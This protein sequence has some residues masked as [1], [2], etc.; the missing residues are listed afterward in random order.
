MSFKKKVFQ[1]LAAAPGIGIGYVHLLNRGRLITPKRRVNIKEVEFEVTRFNSALEAARKQLQLIKKKVSDEQGDEHVYLIEAQLLMLEDKSLTDDTRDLIREEQ[2]N[3]EWAVQKSLERF[4]KLFDQIDDEYF[5]DRRSDIEYVEERLLRILTEAKEQGYVSIHRKT[6]LVAH[7]LSPADIVKI[8]RESLA[9]IVTDIGGRTSHVS[10]MARSLGVPFVVGSENISLEVQNGERIIVDGSQG[11]V[12][13]HPDKNEQSEYEKQQEKYLAAK[14]ELLKNRYHKAETRDH[15]QVHLLANIDFAEEV[16]SVMENGAEGIGMLRTENLFL[17]SSMPVSEEKQFEI[18]KRIVEKMKP[19]ETVIRLF[20]LAGD[21]LFDPSLKKMHVD[22]N[23]ALGL[24]GIRLLLREPDLLRPQLRAILRASAFG[25]V[26]ILYPMVCGVMEVRKA[27]EILQSVMK[28][29]KNDRLK[30]D[31]D[32]R[33]GTMVEIPSAA[34]TANRI[35]Q[36]VDFL[37]IG[38]NDL[39]QYTL[40]VDRSNDLVAGLYDPLHGAVIQLLKQIV[41]FGHKAAI[42]VGVCGEV[43]SEP[44]FIPLLIG[45]EFNFLSVHASAIP[46]V[47]EVVRETSVTEVKTWLKDAMELADP[48]EIREFLSSHYS[49]RYTHVFS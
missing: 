47:K 27:N 2:I 28:E 46:F 3:A 41:E 23:P 6:V 22:Q 5:R 21:S 18:Y 15:Y 11:K 13:L 48:S 44:F 35:A 14:K 34:L 12:L 1:G 9:G 17:E 45:L 26:A 49:S 25:K 20:D 39:V 43:A 36:E 8:N 16:E 31:P 37:S 30:F 7:D 19:R 29:L 24:R 4:R 10:I 32:V 42:E 40:G 33:I 38:T